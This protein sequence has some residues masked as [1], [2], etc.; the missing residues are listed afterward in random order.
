MIMKISII[1]TLLLTTDVNAKLCGTPKNCTCN[2]QFQS[3]DCRGFNVKEIP[4]FTEEEKENILFLEIVNTQIRDITLYKF[5]KSLQQINIINNTL[6]QCDQILKGGRQL[7]ILSN[8]P[9]IED[10]HI[11]DP[12]I[13]EL[14]VTPG[15]FNHKL[16]IPHR[17]ICS[18]CVNNINLLQHN[19][20][21]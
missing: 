17:N 20:R 18:I 7:Y 13:A 21:L 10:P 6:L 4:I 19:N 1:I 15:G 16:V 5:W 9:Y 11:E 14:H 12:H 3:I 8:C 2:L